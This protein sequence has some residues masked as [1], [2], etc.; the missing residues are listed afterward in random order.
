MKPQ[1]QPK[2]EESNDTRLSLG[3]EKKD[4]DKNNNLLQI[5]S[6][7]KDNRARSAKPFFLRKPI[8]GPI[9]PNMNPSSMN[10]GGSDNYLSFKRRK[11][12]ITKN[13]EDIDIVAE[14]DYEKNADSGDERLSYNNILLYKDYPLSS[15]DDEIFDKNDKIENNNDNKINNNI[16][17]NNNN[18]S[19]NDFNIKII[20]KGK[21][22]GDK[23]KRI[24]KF[25]IKANDKMKLQKYTD[26]TSIILDNQFKNFF[27]E[28][29]G[30]K[31]DKKYY[32]ENNKEILL[33]NSFDL[34]N[35]T[36]KKRKSIYE[37]KNNKG[38]PILGFL[39]MNEN[40]ANNTQSSGLSEI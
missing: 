13:K 32:L 17:N 21:L 3:L 10:L 1:E 37:C 14:E 2:K 18:N 38:P 12:N 7:S 28:N 11:K 29:Y 36:I 39:Q 25:F 4:K 26:D 34:D 22:V 19:T 15:S 8:I 24:R 20:N 16:S 40:S 35:L 33:N 9:K 5:Q 31:C 27:K 23:I 30:Y 6:T